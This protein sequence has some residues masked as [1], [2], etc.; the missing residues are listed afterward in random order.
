M[1]QSQSGESSPGRAVQR[2][3][4]RYMGSV[5]HVTFD[6][7]RCI[8]AAECVRGLPTVFDTKRRPWIL[9]TAAAATPCFSRTV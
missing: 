8:H 2:A 7:A 6:G 3:I 4:K 5:I 9:P 1:S